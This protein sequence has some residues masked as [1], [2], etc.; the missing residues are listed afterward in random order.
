MVVRPYHRE[1]GYC[2]I[3][4]YPVVTLRQYTFFCAL[5]QQKFYLK[6]YHR[7]ALAVFTLHLP[8]FLRKKMLGYD[9]AV[10]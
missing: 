8:I 3:V 9:V 4:P 5:N 6:Y 7:E 2:N 10:A 1:K